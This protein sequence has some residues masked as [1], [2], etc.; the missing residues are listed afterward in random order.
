M[1]N[2]IRM[3]RDYPMKNDTP[4]KLMTIPIIVV[5]L[6]G[7][8]N[9]GANF[10]ITKTKTPEPLNISKWLKQDPEKTGSH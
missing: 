8:G 1:D 9:E 2:S 5:S 7:I 4:G 6:S 3:L 10:C